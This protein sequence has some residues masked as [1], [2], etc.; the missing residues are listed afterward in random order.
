MG[1]T[2]ECHLSE[3][4]RTTVYRVPEYSASDDSGADVVLADTDALRAVLTTDAVNFFGRDDFTT[5]FTT[6][7]TF[8]PVLRSVCQPDS[9]TTGLP[10]LLVLLQRQRLDSWPATAGQ[11]VWSELLD[12]PRAMIV[13]IGAAYVPEIDAQTPL[14]NAVQ[15]ATRIAFGVTE[16][17]EKLGD[18]ASFRAEDGRWLDLLRVTTSPAAGSVARP[19]SGDELDSRCGATRELAGHILSRM[20]TGDGESQALAGLV[21]MLLVDPTTDDAYQ[22]LWFLGLHD[23]AKKFGALRDWNLKQELREVNRHRNQVAHEG[24]EQ[25]DSGLATELLKAA[26]RLIRPGA[27]IDG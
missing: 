12:P 27:S 4:V 14:R 23:R 26:Y 19:I 13:D 15:A 9:D 16:G 8:A 18:W 3:Y 24:V 22:R 11:C 5:Q 6:D 2:L 7:P 1:A 10:L 17:F 20:A 21:E 25:L